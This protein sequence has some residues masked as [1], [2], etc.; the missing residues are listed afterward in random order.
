MVLTNLGDASKG[1]TISGAVGSVL[2]EH[3]APGT[4]LTLYSESDQ[5]GV[6][7]GRLYESN[8]C[9][10]QSLGSLIPI[11]SWGYYFNN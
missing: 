3:V 5:H 9:L 10:S 1:N 6:V 4:H 7:V 8:T 2:A 11:Q